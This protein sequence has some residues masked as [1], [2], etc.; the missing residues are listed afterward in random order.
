MLSFPVPVE[1]LVPQRPPMLLLNRLLTFTQSEGTAD[2]VIAPGNLFR[3]PDDTLHPAAL[4]E[5]MAQGYAVFH[6]YKDHLAGKPVGIGYLAGIQ[7]ADV[8][9]AARIGDRLLVIV[10]ETAVIRPFYRAEARVV[11]DGETLAAAELTLF[12]QPPGEP[13]S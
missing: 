2:A 9:G 5:L 10:R 6:G 13:P 3:L 1:R 8:R 11:R 7:R 12:N 4:I